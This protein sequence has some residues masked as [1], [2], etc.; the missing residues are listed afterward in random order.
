MTKKSASSYFGAIGVK[1][2]VLVF[3]Q[4]ATAVTF[5]APSDP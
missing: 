5:Q 3:G 1:G 4:K 2:I